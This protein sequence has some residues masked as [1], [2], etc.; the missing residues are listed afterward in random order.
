VTICLWEEDPEAAWAQAKLGGC[1]PRLWAQLAA[2]REDEHPDDAIPIYQEQV[3]RAIGAKNNRAYEDAVHL[4]GRIQV[5]MR[6]AGRGDVFPGYAASVRAAH[7]PKRNLVKLLDGR[8][9]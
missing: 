8:G 2:L 4:M 7:K 3:E 5:L 6:R 1:S 9:W